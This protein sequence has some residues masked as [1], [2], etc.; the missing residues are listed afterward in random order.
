ML[1]T[2]LAAGPLIGAGAGGQSRREPVGGRTGGRAD[3]RRCALGRRRARRA[4]P[5]RRSAGPP[6]R[7]VRA[8]LLTHDPALEQPAPLRTHRRGIPEELLVHGLRETSVGRFEHVRIHEAHR[9]QSGARGWRAPVRRSPPRSMCKIAAL[10]APCRQPPW[11]APM[12]GGYCL[13][14]V[15]AP[16]LVRPAGDG[17]LALR[18]HRATKRVQ[19]RQGH[20]RPASRCRPIYMD[21]PFRCMVRVPFL[22]LQWNVVASRKDSLTSG[23]LRTGPPPYRI[24]VGERHA[25]LDS[26]RNPGLEVRC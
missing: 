26:K 23:R 19:N 5:V 7:P 12:D 16:R 6:V 21:G 8:R 25:Q 13:R 9:W 17:A 20:P 1:A 2:S 11:L 18:S 14:T 22:H 24:P 3:G 15:S 10:P 4:A